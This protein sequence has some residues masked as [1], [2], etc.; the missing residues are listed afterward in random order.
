MH[1]YNIMYYV[2]SMDMPVTVSR[3]TVSGVFEEVN[4]PLQ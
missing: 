1:S 3:V 2:Y 4:F